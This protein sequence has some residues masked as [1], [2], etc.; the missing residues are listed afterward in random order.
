MMLARLKSLAR[1]PAHALRWGIWR[2]EL[3]ML[4]L[5]FLELVQQAVECRVGNGRVVEH[6][7]AVLVLA[8]LFAQLG[9]CIVGADFF[10]VARLAGWHGDLG[11]ADAAFKTKSHYARLT[12]LNEG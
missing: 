12:F 9:D 11:L 8:D 1:R 5:K 4:P 6:V 10:W 3:G 7:I 2:D